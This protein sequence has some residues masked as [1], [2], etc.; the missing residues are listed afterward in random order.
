M[1]FAY[2]VSGW[3]RKR[4]WESFIRE[5]QPTAENNILDI[6]F[7]EEEYSDTDNFLEKHYPHTEKITALC[8]ETPEAFLHARKDAD[9]QVPESA[10]AVKKKQA[11]KRYP[12]LEIVTYNGKTFPI[13]NKEFD[14][15]WSNAV[16]EHVGDVE[17]QICFLKEIKRV[18]KRGFITT[19][20]RYFPIEVHTRIP[21]LHFLPKKVFDRFLHFI[22]KAW[23]ADEYMYLLSL[24]D[25]CKRLKAAGITKYKI[26][27]NRLL[28]F[29]LDFVVVF[30]D[31]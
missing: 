13:S 5:I 8:L 15:C 31:E 27:K 14:I 3:N 2:K 17:E 18:A 10:I 21:L 24:S 12:Q 28:F 30:E 9:F 1:S 29:T 6:G 7:S 16:L 19:P 4:K 11:S 20:N 22:G 26:I 25:L 23:A